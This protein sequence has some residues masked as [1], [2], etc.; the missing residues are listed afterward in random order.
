MKHTT[1]TVSGHGRGKFLGYPTLNLVIPEGFSSD[2]GIY[3]G[4]VW[5]EN[6]VFLG[7]FHYGP[8]PTYKQQEASLEVFV[9]DTD[10]PKKPK[11]VSFSLVKKLREIVAF[12]RQEELIAQIAKDVALTKQML[13][14]I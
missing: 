6:K 3:A 9:L 8:V 11:V 10:I 4:K 2:F 1:Q 12:E 13:D 14:T 5:L 7:A